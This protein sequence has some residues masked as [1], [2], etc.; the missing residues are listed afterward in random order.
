MVHGTPQTPQTGT[1][2]VAFAEPF[3]PSLEAALQFPQ[4]GLENHG[5]MEDLPT[6]TM[7]TM[8]V[9]VCVYVYIYRYVYT[10][11]YIYTYVYIY[12]TNI[13]IYIT[14]IKVY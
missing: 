13:Y 6:R 9:C 3:L 8:H 5:N 14:K 4:R 1:V 11:I 2:D 10:Y 12:I 7:V